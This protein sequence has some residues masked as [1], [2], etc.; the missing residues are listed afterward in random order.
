MRVTL[1]QIKKAKVERYYRLVGFNE[2]NQLIENV[3]ERYDNI[4]EA[5]KHAKEYVNQNKNYTVQIWK[6]EYNR[7]TSYR[8]TKT[9]EI[10]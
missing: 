7:I 3:I 1:E 10:K 4:N 5:K 8:R 6:Y 2:Q 9:Y